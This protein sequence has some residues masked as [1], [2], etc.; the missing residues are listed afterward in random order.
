MSPI[1]Y[2]YGLAF[3]INGI[4]YAIF[5]FISCS[6]EGNAMANKVLIAI[7]LG[8][9]IVGSA[10][11]S[12]VAYSKAMI[13]RMSAQVVTVNLADAETRVTV[14]L[15]RGGLGKSESF[16]SIVNRTHPTAAITGTFFDTRSMI[17]T[18]DIA[19]FGRV[20]HTGCIGAALCIDSNNRAAVVPLSVG[21]KSGWAGYET[22][23]CCGP[24]LVSRGASS[25]SLRRDGFGSSL[26]APATRT[27]VG[28]TRTGKLLLVALNK[29]TSIHCIANVMVALGATEALALD[30][31]SSTGFYAHGK[32]AANPVRRL[33]NLLVVYSKSSDY[34]NAKF[35]LVPA[36]MLPKISA[37]H[38]E[39]AD[40]TIATAI[41]PMLDVEISQVIGS[42]R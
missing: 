2:S 7:L 28:I 17:P 19:V 36:S 15:A 21:R 39:Q 16:K 33:T 13:G 5:L 22:V 11:A 8:N 9:I 41:A 18:G 4:S 38:K 12:S 35:A 24:K 10:S 20:V 40:R 26:C 34:Q 27:A 31:G 32:F 30:G 23:I 6:P 25:V 29:K 1:R 3:H 14:A 42:P 37:E